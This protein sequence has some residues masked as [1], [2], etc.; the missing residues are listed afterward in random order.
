[1][2]QQ[3]EGSVK[4]GRLDFSHLPA[5]AKFLL[6][7]ELEAF[8]DKQLELSYEEQIPL[9][10]FF[11]DY[12]REKVREL[13]LN[14]A[15]ELLTVFAENRSAEYIEKS[16]REYARNMIPYFEREAVVSEDITKVSLIRRKALR[17][18]LPRYSGDI[19]MYIRVMEEVD[20][21]IAESETSSFNEF[22]AIQQEKLQRIYLQL[23]ESQA[24]FLEAQKLTDMG[25]FL[26]DF[27]GKN[28]VYTPGVW[29]IFEMEGG[30]SVEEFMNFVH[31]DDRQMLKDALHKA[32]HIDGVYDC[33]YRYLKNGKEKKIMSRGVVHF[34]EGKPVMMKGTIRDITNSHLLQEKLQKSEETIREKDV[35]LQQLVVSLK[36]KNAE[37]ER[38]NKELESFNYIA[39]HDL[40]EPLRKIRT[41]THRILE[42]DSKLPAHSQEFLGKIIGSA[43]RMQLLIEDLLMFSQTTA[44]DSHYEYTD[45][46][47]VCEEVQQMLGEIMEEKKVSVRSDDLP[48]LKVI[49]F[50]FR[51]LFLNLIGN[52]IKYSREGVPPVISISTRFVKG[53][54]IH[55]PLAAKDRKF[56]AINFS[57]NG[58]GFEPENSERIFGLFQR[59]HH[60]DKYMGTGIGLA[61]CKKIAHIHNG[62]IQASSRPG[63]GSE[64]T[65]FIPMEYVYKPDKLA[66]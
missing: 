20:Q 65:L 36:H 10:K 40:Q 22:I 63:Q 33:E 60:K 59:L 37:L 53:D 62:Y 27:S 7:N 24:D 61:I 13:A 28:S 44:N 34:D 41:F 12:D 39:S 32:M 31:P 51:Q 26:W 23:A 21:F 64:F 48:V 56:V 45:L 15:K 43:E 3:A 50:Q 8:A 49:P 46:N 42:K 52:S 35:N 58:I 66:N 19:Q 30:S 9:L 17:L 2:E 47:S 1:M 4:K 5:Y 57:D 54:S 18:F 14:G 16:A 25:S 55:D 6:E 38:I 11:K 29:K